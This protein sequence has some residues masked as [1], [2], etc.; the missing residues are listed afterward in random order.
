MS[1]TTFK[2]GI[3]FGGADGTNKIGVKCRKVRK[4]VVLKGGIEAAET[5]TGFTLPTGAIVE[6]V[7]IYVHTVDATETVD[8]GTDGSGSNDPNGFASLLSLAT[9]GIVRP[10]VTVTAGGTETYYS[11]ATRGAL[12]ASFNAG[13]DVAGDTGHYVEFPDTTSGGDVI[14]YTCSAGTDTAVFDI[15]VDYSVIETF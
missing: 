10:G 14:T 13:A 12:L 3:S 1:G 6:D 15:I 2:T 7:Y 5:S 4:S 9:A 11:A 8:I